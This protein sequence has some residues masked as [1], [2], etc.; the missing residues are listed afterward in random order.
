MANQ[1]YENKEIMRLRVERR[2][3]YKMEAMKAL[4]LNDRIVEGFACASKEK[5][6]ENSFIFS[7]VCGSIADEMM[8]ED[9]RSELNEL[10]N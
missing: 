8:K 2:L 5:M 9:E 6:I 4:L 10:N 7:V 1:P 3:T